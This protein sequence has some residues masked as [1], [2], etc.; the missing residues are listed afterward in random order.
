MTTRKKIVS[1]SK[2]LPWWEPPA[3]E[4][5]EKK[6]DAKNKTIHRKGLLKRHASRSHQP[7]VGQKRFRKNGGAFSKKI[8]QERTPQ[9][10]RVGRGTLA[11]PGGRNLLT[12]WEKKKR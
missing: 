10:K 5:E 11:V 8:T 9:Q 12:F 6:K 2:K 1:G 3:Q 7:T 4:Q